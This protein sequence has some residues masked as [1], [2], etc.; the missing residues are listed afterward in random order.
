[1][2]DFMTVKRCSVIED[3]EDITKMKI[4]SRIY[5][6]ARD[7]A[8]MFNSDYVT[9]NLRRELHGEVLARIRDRNVIFVNALDIFHFNKHSTIPLTSVLSA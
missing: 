1:M 9:R 7:G 3:S 4:V 5:S 2:L 8:R 6:R